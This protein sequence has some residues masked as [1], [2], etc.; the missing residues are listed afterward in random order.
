MQQFVKTFATVNQHTPMY[1]YLKEM[2]LTVYMVQLGG[3]N[4][5]LSYDWWN[6]TEASK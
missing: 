4:L 1:E 6:Q 5:R 3:S 2:I